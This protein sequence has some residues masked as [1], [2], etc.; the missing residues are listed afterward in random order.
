MS[1]SIAC[2]ILVGL[3][4]LQH[5]GTHKIGFLFAPV[6]IMWLLFIS[7]V[8]V[9]N[10]FHW[11]TWIIRALSPEYMYKFI[12]SKDIKNWRS[13]GGILLCIAGNLQNLELTFVRILQH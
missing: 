5:Y 7:G 12:K 11:N 1:V 9:Y 13:L 10:I 2:T 6:I 4:V 8:G 3:F